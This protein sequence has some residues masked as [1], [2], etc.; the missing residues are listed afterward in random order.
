MG[1]VPLGRRVVTITVSD[2]ALITLLMQAGDVAELKTPDGKVLGVFT[3]DRP[4]RL[5]AGTRSP[6]TDEQRAEMRAQPPG[7]PLADIL[8]D[9]GNRQ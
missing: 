7:R 5:P 8:R 3:S 6:F 2:P 4:G 1:D 9:L